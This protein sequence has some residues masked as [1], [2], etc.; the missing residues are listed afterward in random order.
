MYLIAHLPIN[1]VSCLKNLRCVGL[2]AVQSCDHLFPGQMLPGKGG[3]KDI[4][5]LALRCILPIASMRLPQNHCKVPTINC[6]EPSFDS[7]IWAKKSSLTA[8]R[9]GVC[10]S[11]ADMLLCSSFSAP[12]SKR[13]SS[14]S[15]LFLSL[16]RVSIWFVY[17]D[18][19]YPCFTSGIDILCVETILFSILVI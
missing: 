13:F 9:I 16:Q 4:E 8:L 11:L 3:P 5:I 12:S 10:I 18:D 19:I 1:T 2:D 15:I 7:Q 6:L 14:A 17:H